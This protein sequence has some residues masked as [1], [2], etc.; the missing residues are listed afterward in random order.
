MP[1]TT[2]LRIRVALAYDGTEYHG[3]ARQPGLPTIQEAIETALELIFRQPVGVTVAGRTDAG[4]HALGQVFHFDIDDTRW[5]A[6]RG[7]RGD[8]QPAQAIVSKLNGVLGR[9]HSAIRV[10][11]ASVA[12][13]DFDARFSPVARSYRYRI[14][15]GDPNPLTRYFTYHHRKP[16]DA[17]LM[18]AEIEGLAGLHDFGSFCKPRPGATTVRTLK[19]FEIAVESGVLIIKLQADAFC[20]HMVRALVGALVQVGDGSRA[21]GWLRSRLAE[22]V[23]DSH[24]VIA[25]AHGLVLESVEYPPDDQVAARAA[26][27]R[28]KR[29]PIQPPC[30]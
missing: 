3:W 11:Q 14:A 8:L 18:A 23:R 19:R 16:L 1:D 12:P 10:V 6:L 27:T 9:D 4:V 20:H 17:E 24:M 28:A 22:P 5:D 21:P 26:Q 7:Q 30:D 2:T 15:L 25:P 29:Q 13:S